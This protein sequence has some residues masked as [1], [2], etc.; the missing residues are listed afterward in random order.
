MGAKIRNSSS[1]DAVNWV[2]VATVLVFLWYLGAM[3]LAERTCDNVCQAA[4]YETHHAA[5]V[6]F[7]WFSTS[8]CECSNPVFI[9]TKE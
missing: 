6:S 7:W 5:D 4:G 1:F 9:D 2:L 8:K 3:F